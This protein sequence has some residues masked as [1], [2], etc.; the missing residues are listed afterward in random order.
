[1]RRGDETVSQLSLITAQED[2]QTPSVYGDVKQKSL[3]KFCIVLKKSQDPQNIRMHGV[4][5]LL[6]PSCHLKPVWCPLKEQMSTGDMVKL[7]F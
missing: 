6:Q 3:W 5:E 7:I 1:M 4:M 2:D